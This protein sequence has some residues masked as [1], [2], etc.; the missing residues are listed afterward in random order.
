LSVKWVVGIWCVACFAGLLFQS[1][2][3]LD[4]FD[5][6]SKLSLAIADIEFEQ[7]LVNQLQKNTA[8]LPSRSYIFQITIFLRN[9]GESHIARL[10]RRACERIASY[11]E[12]VQRR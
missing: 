3:Q 11:C 6:E 7:N 1:V 4:E 10:S 12:Q 9:T 8:Q 2:S 5:P